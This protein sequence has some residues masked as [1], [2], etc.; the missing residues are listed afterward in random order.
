VFI[1]GVADDVSEVTLGVILLLVRVFVLETVGTTTHQDFNTPVH[2]AVKFRSIFVS[3]QVAD[4]VGQAPV[5]ALP[6]VISFTAVA[7]CVNLISSLFAL[8]SIGWLAARTRAVLVAVPIVTLPFPCPLNTALIFAVSPSA[9]SIT[10]VQEAFVILQWFTALAV[11]S[12]TSISF[13]FASAI[14]HR[15]ANLGAVSVLLV[16]VSVLDAVILVFN[17]VCIA[18]VTH[19]Q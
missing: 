4:T 10:E 5:A 9:S 15:S 11:V 8:S 12:K 6:I 2:L 3:S 7:A 18:L 19:F 1:V 16:S 13:P 17:C 14:N